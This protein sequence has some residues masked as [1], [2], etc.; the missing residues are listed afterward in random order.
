MALVDIPWLGVDFGVID[1]VLDLQM[2]EIPAP[3]VFD[4]MEGFAVRATAWKNP[5]VIV[6]PRR[7]H[8]QRVAVPFSD[9]VP[10]NSDWDLWEVRVHPE[11]FGDKWFATLKE[12]PPFP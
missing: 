7:I 8:Y 12:L 4:D 5:L 10:A 2:V 11:R 3:V 1:C 9:G 6:E